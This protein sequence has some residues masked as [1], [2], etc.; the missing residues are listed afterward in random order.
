VSISNC[1]HDEN[2]KY[3]SGQAGDQTG[4][5]WYI[6]S[7]YNG[8]WKAMFRHPDAKVR[9]LIAQLATEAA[10]NDKVGYDQ[11]ERTTFWTQLQKV[12]YYPSKIT[13]ACEA[14]CSSGVGAIVKAA[15][16]ILGITALQNVSKDIYTGNERAA[17]L[18]AGFEEYT[19]SKYL[20]GESYLMAGDILL[21]NSHTVIEVSTGSNASAS[22]TGSTTMASAA[23]PCKGWQ[24]AEVR[25]LQSALIAKGYSCGSSGVDGDFG[26]DTDAAVR[27]YQQDNGL[28]VD[29]IVGPKTQAKLYAS[30]SSSSSSTAKYT[31]GNYKTCVDGLRVRTGAG[32]NYSI[33]AKSQLTADGQKHSDSAG[34]LY[35]GTTVTVSEVK[36]V[37]SDWWGKIPSGWICL[38]YQG[39]PYAVKS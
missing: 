21:S 36:Q 12:G 15:G 30:T 16:Y 29:G 35:S 5:E 11:Y 24:G 2:G 39:K 27:K 22:S 28:E 7:W 13:V 3:N 31:T 38:E 33:K 17:L 19:A 14:D 4:T 37:G 32:T 25:K 23:Y 18:A 10:N 34:Q 6:R 26:P 20:T 9:S 8:N 1:G